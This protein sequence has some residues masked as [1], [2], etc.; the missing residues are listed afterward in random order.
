MV[1]TSR[2]SFRHAQ[3]YIGAPACPSCALLRMISARSNAIVPGG[4]LACSAK[5]D[6]DTLSIASGATLQVCVVST[7]PSSRWPDAVAEYPTE[8]GSKNA[9]AADTVPKIEPGGSAVAVRPATST[10]TW[11]SADCISSEI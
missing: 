3:M 7:T 5:Y 1:A 10:R 6:E 8:P 9:D 2:C 4:H 11:P